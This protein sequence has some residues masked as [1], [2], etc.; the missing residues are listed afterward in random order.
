MSA[1]KIY[2]RA[3]SFMVLNLQACTC[4]TSR[5][6]V[7]LVDYEGAGVDEVVMRVGLIRDKR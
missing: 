4:R 6:L 2:Q 3:L 1:L 5:S 7:L